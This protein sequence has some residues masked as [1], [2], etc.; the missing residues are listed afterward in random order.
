MIIFIFLIVLNVQYNMSNDNLKKN[1]PPLK[2]F[3][4]IVNFSGRNFKLIFLTCQRQLI[5]KYGYWGETHEVRTQDGYI[6]ELH[7][8]TGP[9]SNRDPDGKQPILLVHGLLSSSIDWI[10]MGPDSAFGRS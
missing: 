9:N 6:L 4:K 8:I 7:R 1:L 3:P 5:E 2:K 10:I